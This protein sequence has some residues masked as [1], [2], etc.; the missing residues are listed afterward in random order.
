MQIGVF[1]YFTQDFPFGK[2]L[3]PFFKMIKNLEWK[4]L[5]LASLEQM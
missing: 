4:L 2:L 5:D 1:C 3:K